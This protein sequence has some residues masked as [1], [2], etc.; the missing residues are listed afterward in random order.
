MTQRI[1]LVTGAGRGLGNEV[2]LEL[3]RRGVHVV[4]TSRTQGALEALDDA[5]RAMGQ[6]ATLLPLDLTEGET[7]DQIGPSL[8]ARFGRL[9]ILVHAAATLGTLTPAHHIT[10]PDWMQTFAVNATAAWRLIR[11]A[12]PLLLAAEAGRAVFVT[13][14]RATQ[15]RAF[16]GTYGASKAAQHNLVLAWAGETETTQ[17]RIN[18]VE[19]PPMATRLRRFAMPG[20]DQET[21]AKPAQFAPAIADLCEPGE[22]RHAAVVRL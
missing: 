14:T 9:D 20:E 5:I 17:L 8:Y 13:D 3:A 10:E 2:A 18:L 1:A 15:P 16:W 21:L 12:G 6:E 19:P 7:V 11:T 22:Q 4:A